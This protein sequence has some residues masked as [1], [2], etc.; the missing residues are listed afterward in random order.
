MNQLKEFILASGSP[1]RAELLQQFGIKFSVLVTDIDE[2]AEENEIPGVYVKRMAQEKALAG[3]RMSSS[4][5]H[6]L[7]AD[8]VVLLDGHILGKPRNQAEAASM[9]K[10]L[11]GC[12]HFV[13]TAV[14]L[15][16]SSNHA[17]VVLN[18]TGVT[19]SDIPDDFIQAYS[20]SGE[21]MD[22]AGAYAIQGGP[23]LFV[24]RVEGSYSGV[25]GLPMY[26]T[27]CLLRAAGILA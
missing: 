3:F 23:G 9:L 17:E 22:K 20:T 16:S 6:V 18:R 11:S 12:E 1:R 4:G 26:E 5:N 21:P 19:F 2:S 8:T 15:T 13:L 10:R 14:A 7:G 24:S 27:G 25:M